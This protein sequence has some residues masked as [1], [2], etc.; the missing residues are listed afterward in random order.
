[1]IEM[2]YKENTISKEKMEHMAYKASMI[3]SCYKEFWNHNKFNEDNECIM[4]IYDGF[5]SIME[6]LGL[7]EDV[8]EENTYYVLLL[9]IYNQPDGTV[10]EKQM[11]RYEASETAYCFDNYEA[12]LAR[13]MD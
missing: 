12:A 7:Y 8:I 4:D 3:K 1:M 9:D 6:D 13:A 11:T 5:L 2:S 10:V